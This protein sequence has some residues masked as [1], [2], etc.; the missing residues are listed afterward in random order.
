MVISYTYITITR[1]GN[2]KLV[3]DW[4]LDLSKKIES[5]LVMDA[6]ANDLSQEA[7]GE[8][9]SHQLAVCPTQRT[10][11]QTLAHYLARQLK[12]LQLKSSIHIVNLHLGIR[13]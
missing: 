13:Q 3:L 11:V 6:K 2:G 1:S 7:A 4:F 5:D 10:L 9:R 12:V 8:S